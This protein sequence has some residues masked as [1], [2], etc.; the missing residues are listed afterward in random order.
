M[1]L[2]ND[3]TKVVEQ[4]LKEAFGLD[5]KAVQELYNI[6]PDV[7]EDAWHDVTEDVDLDL[8]ATVHLETDADKFRQ[9]LK[10]ELEYAI[11]DGH[12]SA[13]EEAALRRRFSD[14]M[15]EDMLDEMGIIVDKYGHVGGNAQ[16][17]PV[18]AYTPVPANITQTGEFG[19]NRNDIENDAKIYEKI[20]S[21]VRNGNEPQN[22]ILGNI[23]AELVRSNNR[24]VNVNV[25]PSS[26]WGGF[27]SRSNDAYQK[28]TG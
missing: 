23:L 27:N 22:A 3:N 14:A 21:G 11:W 15:F 9:D 12:L 5:E 10:D 26:G 16:L 6:P 17:A 28:V 8:N 2:A 25:I 7:F 24:P 4:I 20:E 13:E 19:T 18:N 1:G